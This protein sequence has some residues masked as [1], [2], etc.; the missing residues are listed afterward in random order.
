MIELSPGAEGNLQTLEIMKQ[1][2][3]ERKTSPLVRQTA[4]QIIQSVPQNDRVAECLAIGDW[5]RANMRYTFDVASEEQLTD[6]LTL[7]DQINK[8]IPCTSSDCDDMSLLT[9]TLLLSIGYTDIV[10]CAVRYD[11]TATSRDSF[12]HV[13]TAVYVKDFKTGQEIRIPLDCILPDAPMGSEVESA[14]LTEYAL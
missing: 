7:L 11:K 9:A 13:Y 10:F 1:V 12:D 14:S 6:P 5:V 4:L 3:Q 8:Q 2:A